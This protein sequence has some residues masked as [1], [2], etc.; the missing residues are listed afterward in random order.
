MIA[1]LLKLQQE[2]VFVTKKEWRQRY[3]SKSKKLSNE[4]SIRENELLRR[5]LAVYVSNDFATKKKI[6]RMNHDDFDASHFARMRIEDAI[7]RKYYWLNM[8]DD[9]A[10][11]V[12][13]C[14]NC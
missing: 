13:N 5:D 11:Y 10:K 1:W 9:I 2:N 12:R 14:S 8:I 6:L 3:A 4:W 7:R